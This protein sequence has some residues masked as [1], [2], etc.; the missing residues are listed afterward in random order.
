MPVYLVQYRCQY[1]EYWYD[2]LE[3]DNWAQAYQRAVMLE[4]AGRAVR[5]YDL[6]TGMVVYGVNR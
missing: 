6:Q 5:V 3:T 4:A 2:D 1:R